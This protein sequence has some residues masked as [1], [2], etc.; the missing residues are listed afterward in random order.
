M[1]T[2]LIMNGIQSIGYKVLNQ[3]L[4]SP[5]IGSLYPRCL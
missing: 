2:E 1:K 5:P 3:I 4:K